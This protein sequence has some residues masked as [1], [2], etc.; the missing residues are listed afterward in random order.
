MQAKGILSIALLTAAAA[1]ACQNTMQ[2]RDT[3]Q[4]G[5]GPKTDISL[6][7]GKWTGR[8]KRDGARRTLEVDTD[9]HGNPI[10]RYCYLSQ[11]RRSTGHTLTHQVITPTKVQFRWNAGPSLFTFELEGDTLRGTRGRHNVFDMKRTS[12]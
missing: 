11:C 8:G 2:R 10:F 12:E 7:A 4:T 6:I 9:E 5:V 1:T 3:S